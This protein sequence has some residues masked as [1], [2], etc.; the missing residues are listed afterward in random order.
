MPEFIVTSGFGEAFR[1]SLHF[2]T[3]VRLGNRV[4]TSGQG[5]WND[6]FESPAA[7]ED[8]IAAAFSNI[9]L[10]LAEAGASWRQVVH[11]NTYHV[12]GLSPIVNETIVRL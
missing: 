10:V 4:E 2:S 12:G 5:G 11:V 8:E 9:A 7:I 3:A 6:D 1:N